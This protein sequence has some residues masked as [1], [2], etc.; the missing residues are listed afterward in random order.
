MLKVFAKGLMKV[1]G[2][3]CV[4]RTGGD[5]FFIF[6]E[7]GNLEE[8]KENLKELK[9]IVDHSVIQ[10]NQDQTMSGPTYAVGIYVRE[11]LDV[12]PRTALHY[13]DQTMYKMKKQMKSEKEVD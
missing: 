9:G 4:M 1:F 13:A 7:A 6:I 2:E 5:E 10:I 12:L 3:G 11:S 8:T